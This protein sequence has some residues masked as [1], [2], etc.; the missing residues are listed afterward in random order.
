MTWRIGPSIFY[1]LYV[2]YGT[3]QKGDPDSPFGHVLSWPG[4]YPHPYQRPAYDE[5][6]DEIVVIFRTHISGAL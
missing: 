3:G 5:L 4:M 2:E 1:S 6:K